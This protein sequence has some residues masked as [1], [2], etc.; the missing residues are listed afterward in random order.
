MGRCTPA[1]ELLAAGG[2]VRLLGPLEALVDDERVELG[3]PQQ[4]M[5][6]AL[7]ALHAGTPCGSVRSTRRCGGDAPPPSAAKIVQTYV[8]RLR[9]LLGAGAIRFVRQG[10]VLDGE[11]QVDVDRFREL[12]EQRHFAEALAL[13]RGPPLA[14]VPALDTEAR[15]L[16][17]LCVTALEDRFAAELERGAGPSLVAELEALVAEH[18]TRERL[19][20]QLVLALYRSGPSSRWL[21]AYRNGREALVGGLGLEPGAAFARA[22]ATD[23]AA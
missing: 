12:I 23:P 8:S 4:R 2:L 18:P 3:P 1:V 19:L 14:D 21:A 22:R 7:L 9:K 6:L 17:E 5:L 15:R 16:E 11:I 20:E 10:Y 13:W